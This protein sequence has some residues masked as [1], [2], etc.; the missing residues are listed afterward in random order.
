MPNKKRILVFAE[1]YLPGIKGGGPI[2]TIKNMV[3]ALSDFFEFRIV[4][5]DRDLGDKEPYKGIKKGWNEVGNASVL[6]LGPKETKISGFIKILK[7]EEYDAIYFNS[8][9]SVKFTLKPLIA[10]KRLKL[11]KQM[12]IAP[13]GEFSKGALQLKSHIKKLYLMIARKLFPLN[14]VIF[15]A[16]SEFEK[17]NIK[18]IFKE[19]NVVIAPNIRTQPIENLPFENKTEGMLKI[20]FLSRISPM[21]NLLYALEVLKEI[22]GELY[23]EIYGPIEDKEYWNK[24]NEIIKNLPA[25][26][27][28]IYCGQIKHDKVIETLNNYH[29]FFLP[30]LGENYGHVIHEALLA[31]CPVLISDQTP[32][33]DLQKKGVGWDIPL[34]QK[35]EFTKAISFIIQLSNKEFREL[36]KKARKYG[37]EVSRDKTVIEANKNLFRKS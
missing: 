12:I 21:K 24:C 3:D 36:S 10:Y 8:F 25:N 35:E 31:G 2:T 34:K 23:F 16:S 7:E 37:A 4:T 33:K 19:A 13:R 22:K 15:Q 14:K 27:K 17:N 18:A 20:V 29:L 5:L 6:Y 32:W 30:T 11:E 1:Y 9:F 28:V 26:V